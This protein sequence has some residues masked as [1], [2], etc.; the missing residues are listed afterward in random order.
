MSRHGLSFDAAL[1]DVESSIGGADVAAAV[2]SLRRAK[3]P[4]VTP[5][6]LFR[7]LDLWQR[8]P[9]AGLMPAIRDLFAYEPSAYFDCHEAPVTANLETGVSFSRNV[10]YQRHCSFS[11]SNALFEFFVTTSESRFCRH[12]RGDTLS[13]CAYTKIPLLTPKV[14][15]CE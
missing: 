1:D 6:Q 2:D 8:A 9:N 5:Y 10:V 4:P 15:C 3:P 11:R 14:H 13:I 12:H 7:L